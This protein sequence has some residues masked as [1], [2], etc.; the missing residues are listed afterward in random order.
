MTHVGDPVRGAEPQVRRFVVRIFSWEAEHVDLVLLLTLLLLL[1]HAPKDWYSYN[2]IVALVIAGI[3]FRQARES[4][5]FWF[6]IASLLG[7]NVY[8]NWYSSD[9][10]KYLEFYWTLALFGVL[11]LPAP[12]REGALAL[13]ARL[14]IGLCMVLAASGSASPRRTSPVR[15]SSASRS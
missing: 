6:A 5:T 3:A 15:H 2:P 12:R 11:S 9:N 14:L 1:L 8:F 10:H 13:N 7:S 4:S